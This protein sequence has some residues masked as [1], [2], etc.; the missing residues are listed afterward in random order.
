V[1]NNDKADDEGYAPAADPIDAA[2]HEM[3][4]P[5]PKPAHVILIELNVTTVNPR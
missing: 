2:S 3:Q 1:G 5:L 4:S